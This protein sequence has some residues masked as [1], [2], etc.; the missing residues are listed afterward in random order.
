MRINA[1]EK[2]A[3]QWRCLSQ[4]VSVV[5]MKLSDDGHKEGKGF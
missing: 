1:K 5:V 3:N 4:Q 2:K